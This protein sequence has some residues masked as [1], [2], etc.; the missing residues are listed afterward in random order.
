MRIAVFRSENGPVLEISVLVAYA[1][2]RSIFTQINVFLVSFTIF[3]FDL[4][5][6]ISKNCKYIFFSFFN[7]VP[8]LI[9]QEKIMQ[10]RAFKRYI[11]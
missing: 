10:V 1:R 7:L 4:E 2:A 8:F 3:H 6:S 11:P 9:I 5:K